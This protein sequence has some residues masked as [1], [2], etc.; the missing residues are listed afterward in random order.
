MWLSITEG[1]V[2]M[3]DAN[4]F[5]SET[6]PTV[7]GKPFQHDIV[8]GPQRQAYLVCIEGAMAVGTTSEGE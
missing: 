2:C 5:V 1:C 3:Q 4:V 8:L 6:D 7:D